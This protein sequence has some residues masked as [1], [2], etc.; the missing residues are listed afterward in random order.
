MASG[1]STPVASGG[2]PLLRVYAT[3]RFALSILLLMGYFAF[4]P[5]LTDTP[6]LPRLYLGTA[7][8]YA[9]LNLV[10]LIAVL[11]RPRQP[12]PRHFFAMLTLD[13]V[14][15]I[16]VTHASGGINSGF[17]ILL[18][19]TVAAAATFVPGQVATLVAAVASLA[20]LADA[21]VLIL[22]R[23]NE[24]GT[25]MPA[26]LLGVLLF[27]SSLLVQRLA[28]RL[29]QSQELAQARAAEVKELQQLNQMIVQR[30]RTGI[31]FVDAGDK[32][33]I[34]NEAAAQMLGIDRPELAREGA[35]LA[36][37]PVLRDLLGLWRANPLRA[38]TPLRL[39]EN[40]PLLQFAFMQLS[41]P[42]GSGTLV[43]AEDFTRIAQQAQQLKLASLGRLTASIAHEIRNPLSSISHAAQL[44]RESPVLPLDD[45]RLV[46]IVIGNAHRTNEVI[47]SVLSLSRGQEPHPELLRLGDWLR[48]FVEELPRR[49]AA[50][51]IAIEVADGVAEPEVRVDPTQLRQVLANLCENGLRYSMRATGTAS[52]R[53][54][55]GVE[56][57]TGLPQ[58]DVVDQG[59]G[60]AEED[61]TKIFEPFF[62]TE[63]SGT[64]LGLYLARE[65]CE[66]NQIRLVY[67]NEA[68][69]GSCF[70]L[71]FPHP[72]R[73][74]VP[75]AI[76][77]ARTTTPAKAQMP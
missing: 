31:L 49:D 17:A 40:G 5:G 38:G 3:Y 22:A 19:V 35:A 26:G 24:L 30:M 70:R 7:L 2:D 61:V 54:V 50:E 29:R 67:L 72:D 20:V 13:I 45:A 8:P 14:A 39:R 36:L 27:A 75:A 11:A 32:V 4:R 59:S 42:S 74:S 21:A 65:L 23:D 76:Q 10:T 6:F 71:N 34:A 69:T 73:R 15:L 68:G 60:V 28:V 25:L 58:L 43:F 52:L 56:T 51:H 53:L 47:E 44:L 63:H 33:R 55:I 16:L 77:P 64:G 48:R 1:R 18:M 12:R 57:G 37:P 66:A 9:I 41:G 62:T 46:D